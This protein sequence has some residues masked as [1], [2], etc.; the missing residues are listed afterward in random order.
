MNILI[1]KI[2]NSA[3]ALITKLLKVKNV[4]IYLAVNEEDAFRIAKEIKPEI[5]ITG[6]EREVGVRFFKRFSIRN[7]F[8]NI[9]QIDE[10]I[11]QLNELNLI[12]QRSNK[13]IKFENLINQINEKKGGHYV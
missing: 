10:R 5:I 8:M 7:S 13:K 9:F 1:F 11:I 4:S 12:N 6:N 3:T 2:N